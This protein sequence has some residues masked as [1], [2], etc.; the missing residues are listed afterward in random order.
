MA[1]HS[2]ILA[3]EIPWIEEPGSSLWGHKRVRHDLK[4]TITTCLIGPVPEH[5]YV[6]SGSWIT[7][8]TRVFPCLGRLRNTPLY[9]RHGKEQL[10]GLCLPVLLPPSS[11]TCGSGTRSKLELGLDPTI[12]E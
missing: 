8:Q 9:T 4:T 5:C 6:A 1:T 12:S 11:F 10:T 7:P 3:W 2:S